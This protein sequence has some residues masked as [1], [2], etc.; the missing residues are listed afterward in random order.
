MT[1]LL[2]SSSTA[3]AAAMM[4]YLAAAH[5][6]PL[7]VTGLPIDVSVNV[8]ERS[9]PGGTL[10]DETQSVGGAL[11]D[12]KQSAELLYTTRGSNFSGHSTQI[13]SSFASALSESN[14]NLGVGVSSWLGG[15]GSPVD[16]TATGQLVAQATLQQ[17]FTY[18]GALAAALKLHLEIP[19]LIVGLIGVPPNRSSVSAAETAEALV[20]L[21]SVITHADGSTAKGGSYEFGM[22]AFERQF[23]NGSTGTFL[24]FADVEFI[25]EPGVDVAFSTSGNDSVPQFNVDAFSTDVS[26]GSLETGDTVSYVYTLLATGTTRGFE[27]GY[28]AFVGDPFGLSATAGNLALT[29]DTSVP[30]VPDASVPEPQ[31]L[32]LALAGLGGLAWRRR[33]G[34]AR[35]IVQ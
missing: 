8:Q 2:Q 1:S 6:D 23:A 7:D 25:G 31:T 16:P 35:S 4:A 3:V 28:Y 21:S 27:R 5:A 34:R 26:L 29:L 24:N 20:T 11:P 14:G 15:P 10:H 17:S 30:G 19:S 18:N 13:T 9:N 33:Q 12:P 22:K 32:A